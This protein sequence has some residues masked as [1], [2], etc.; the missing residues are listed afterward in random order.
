MFTTTKI[1][2]HN[3]DTG[4]SSM[5]EFSVLEHTS[6]WYDASKHTPL[7]VFA[8][9]QLNQDALEDYNYIAVTVLAKSK[10]IQDCEYI[11]DARYY[12]KTGRYRSEGSA[13]QIDAS[14]IVAFC[15]YGENA[16]KL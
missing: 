15:F 12:Y 10:T 3:Q 2:V 9:R 11:E 7:D 5:K 14:E 8:L 4:V 6:I 13:E 16:P 1:S